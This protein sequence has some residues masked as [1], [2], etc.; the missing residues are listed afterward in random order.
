MNTWPD[1]GWNPFRGEKNT[2]RQGA[3]DG[4]WREVSMERPDLEHHL[5]EIKDGDTLKVVFTE[6]LAV[7]IRAR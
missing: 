2:N 6:A 1:A 7:S 5:E 3:G 4:R